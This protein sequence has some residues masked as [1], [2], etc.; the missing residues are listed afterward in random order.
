MYYGF[1]NIKR[2]ISTIQRKRG[3]IFEKFHRVT[4]LPV[5]FSERYAVITLH[6][7]GI[8]FSWNRVVCGRRTKFPTAG[9]LRFLPAANKARSRFRRTRIACCQRPGLDT[10]VD[11]SE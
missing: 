10:A 2:L 3:I 8:R 5:Y 6:Q 1:D 9:V 7:S 11:R 4:A